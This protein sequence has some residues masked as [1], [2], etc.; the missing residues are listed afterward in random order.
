MQIVA[1]RD[2]I[3]S[4]ARASYI[5]AHVSSF[6]ERMLALRHSID[7]IRHL[8]IG[9]DELHDARSWDLVLIM[10]FDSVDALR[11]Y[12]AHPE[13]VALMHFN[14]PFVADVGSVDFTRT[15]T[16]PRR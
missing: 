13:H 11:A 12:Q 5:A 4:S 2:A 6:C 16:A 7:Q 1:Q 15:T 14:N 3:G 10:A 8:E 9:R